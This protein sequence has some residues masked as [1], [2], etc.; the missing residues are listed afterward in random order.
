[1]SQVWVI[2]VTWKFKSQADKDKLIRL[3]TPL[4]QYVATHEPNTLA[5]ELAY[6]P[7]EPLTVFLYER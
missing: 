4:A 7:D 3:W 6:S 1:M 2:A 5:Y